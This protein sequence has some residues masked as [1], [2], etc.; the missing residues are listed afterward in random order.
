MHHAGFFNGFAGRHGT[1]E[2]V[3]AISEE[4]G[5]VPRSR[6]NTS[7]MIISLLISMDNPPVLRA[8]YSFYTCQW[9]AGNRPDP[10]S[11]ST[12][13]EI[14]SFCIDQNHDRK[15]FDLQ[16]ADASAPRSS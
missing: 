3:Q 10:G 7:E 16:P 9:F 1:T 6:F 15:V 14:V 11:R 4:I 13:I 5:T 2:A 8:L 12:F